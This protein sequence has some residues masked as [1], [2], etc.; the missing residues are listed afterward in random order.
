VIARVNALN[1]RTTAVFDARGQAVAVIDALGYRS[2]TVYDVL[3]RPMSVQ[4]PRGDVITW[5]YD[6]TGRNTAKLR[7]LGNRTTYLYDSIGQEISIQDALGFLNTTLYDALGRGIATI[8]PLGARQTVLYDAAGRQIAEVDALNRRTTTVYDP[9]DRP[10]ALQNARGAITTW[11]YDQLGRQLALVDANGNRTTTLFDVLG[12]TVVTTDP[13][14]AST[15]YLYDPTGNV[16]L[17]I[18]ARSRMTTYTVDPLN[19]TT[20][21]LYTDGSRAT[22][23]FD[24]IGQQ[25]SMQ[26]STGMTTQGFDLVGN[27]TQVV[28]PTGRTLTYFYNSVR[29]RTGMLSPDSSLTS[30]LYDVQERLVGLTNGANQTSTLMWDVLDLRLKETLASGMTISHTYDPAGQETG[31]AIYKRDGAALAVYTATYD[32]VGNRLSVLEV[33]GVRVTYAYDVADQLL[34]ELRSDPVSGYGAS[35]QY[36]PVGNRLL[37]NEIGSVTTYTYN[38]SNELTLIQPPGSSP[39]TLTWDAN[40]NLSVVNAGGAVTTHTWDH[41]NRLVGVQSAT[42]GSDAYT[43]AAD[44]KRQSKTPLGGSVVQ[45]LWDQENLLWEEISDSGTIEYT[46]FPEAWEGLLSQLQSSVSSFYAFDLQSSTRLLVDS[47]GATVRNSYVYR[48]FGER[49][50]WAESVTNPMQFGGQ[51]GYYFDTDTQL[52]LRTRFYQPFQGRFLSVDPA[53]FGVNWLVYVDNSPIVYTDPSGQVPS[54]DAASCKRCKSLYQDLTT[55]DACIKRFCSKLT[56]D[57]KFGAKVGRCAK[58]YKIWHAN[59][60]QCLA[61]WCTKGKKI[62]CL[63]KPAVSGITGVTMCKE[64]T[65]FCPKGCQNAGMRYK[66]SQDCARTETFHLDPGRS[67]T[68]YCCKSTTRWFKSQCPLPPGARWIQSPKTP[69]NCDATNA[70]WLH[71]LG[72]ICG[73]VE[74]PNPHSLLSDWGV[75]VVPSLKCFHK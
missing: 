20:G 6:A 66:E 1:A 5:F 67:Q 42:G 40:G 69:D 64:R 53:R 23:S 19:R 65:Q 61:S 58:R 34:S 73:A 24:P 8:D 54:I 12:R 44:G 45:Y 10:L 43:Y 26:D 3:G 16:V 75:C 2:T 47:D 51:V 30:Y 15:S 28:Y 71:E 36:D 9:N 4:G 33:D 63:D 7:I 52:Y 32:A 59:L 29:S 37:K 72:H 60:W 49:Q 74:T 46:Q 27:K 57:R 48:A 41:E 17:R 18:D 68:R 31:R 14:G 13:L 11:V 21:R 70:I 50:T 55:V 56:T 62:T 22:F 38:A 39:T 25:L 35:Y